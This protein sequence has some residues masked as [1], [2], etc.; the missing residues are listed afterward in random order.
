M[1][2]RSLYVVTKHPRPTGT[3]WSINTQSISRSIEYNLII[4]TEFNNNSNLATEVENHTRQRNESIRISSNNIFKHVKINQVKR[5]HGGIKSTTY[6]VNQ[7][8]RNFLKWNFLTHGSVSSPYRHWSET[9]IETNSAPDTGE[10]GRV[11]T[12]RFAISFQWP[13][14]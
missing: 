9:K 1:Q 4:T 6:G 5:D 2:K 3:S 10:T 11:R 13:G 7:R 14:A 8:L 12:V